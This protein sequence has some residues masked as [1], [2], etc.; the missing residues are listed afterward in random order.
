MCGSH[1]T[2]Y[3][4]KKLNIMNHLLYNTTYPD[5]ILHPHHP[6]LNPPLLQPYNPPWAHLFA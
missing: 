3:N 6:P 5:L 1:V 2:N 4:P